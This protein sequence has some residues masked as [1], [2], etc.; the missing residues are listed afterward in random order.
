[1]AFDAWAPARGAEWAVRRRRRPQVERSPHAKVPRTGEQ[2]GCR[3][4]PERLGVA[5][6]CATEGLGASRPSAPRSAATRRESRLRDTSVANA[7]HRPSG[8]GGEPDATEQVRQSN[9][10]A[11]RV[12][13]PGA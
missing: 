5:Q 8:T 10:T 13:P 3:V 9:S 7:L 4:G 2:P 1:A 12:T 11:G 6:L